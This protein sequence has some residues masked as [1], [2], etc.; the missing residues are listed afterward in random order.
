MLATT[1]G[2][3]RSPRKAAHTACIRGWSNP[4][5]LAHQARPCGMVRS[6]GVAPNNCFSKELR[7]M[8]LTTSDQK[9]RAKSLSHFL[10]RIQYLQ[11]VVVKKMFT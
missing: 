1:L 8:N 11:Q 4:L 9:Q 5:F 2:K 10:D 3:L 7:E 6:V